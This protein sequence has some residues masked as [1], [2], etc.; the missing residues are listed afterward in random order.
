MSIKVGFLNTRYQ[1]DSLNK[2]D[3]IL[4]LNSFTNSNIILL[5]TEPTSTN[6]I[7]IK[8]KNNITT[9]V[10]GGTTYVIDDVVANSRLLSA[11]TNNIQFNRPIIANNTFSVSNMITAANNNISMNLG[12]PSSSRSFTVSSATSA[13]SSN[14]LKIDA[15][16]TT[17]LS[18]DNFRI[19]NSNQTKTLMQITSLQTNINQNL[20]INDGVLYVNTIAPIGNRKIDIQNAE[21]KQPIIESF[22]AT[23]KMSVIQP[24]T[25]GDFL[26]FEICKKYVAT[27]SANVFH[28]YSCNIVSGKSP[29]VFHNLVVNKDGLL[30]LGTNAPDATL[31]IRTLN[32]NIISYSGD[33]YGDIFK[34]TKEADLGIGT[35][36]PKAQVHIRRND[37][38]INDTIRRKPMVYLDMNYD[39]ANNYSNLYDPQN[40]TLTDDLIILSKPVANTYVL[41]NSFNIELT[42]NFYMINNTIFSA[43][44]NSV[45]NISNIQL[46]N[47]E[48]IEFSV[49]VSQPGMGSMY[50]LMNNKLIYP[51]SDNI[52]I[53]EDSTLRAQ[54]TFLEN[55][56]TIYQASYVF[57]MMSQTTKLTQGGYNNNPNAGYFNASN[58]TNYLTNAVMNK[59]NNIVYSINTYNI[60]VK[61]DFVFE[62]NLFNPF[63]QTAVVSYPIIYSVITRTLL[64][65]PQFMQFTYN[66]NFVS[67]ITT[68]GTLCI[69]SDLPATQKNKNYKIYAPDGGIRSQSINVSVIDTDQ[70][71]SNINISGKN[72]A[73]VNKLICKELDVASLAA[74]NIDFNT[75]SGTFI[76]MDVGHFDHIYT[77]NISFQTL[78]TG[79]LSMNSNSVIFQ[80]RVHCGSVSSGGTDAYI[81]IATDSNIVAVTTKGNIFNTN[82][83]LMVTN[84]DTVANIN[85]AITVQTVN[86]STT[87]YLCLNNS[88]TS[89]YFRV[90]TT[91]R[92]DNSTNTMFQIANDNID[93][94]RAAYFV[95]NKTS[96]HIMQHIKEYN[97]LSFGEQNTICIDTLRRESN[98]RNNIS[99]ISIGIPYGSIAQQYT[100]DDYP[101]YF[102]QTIN[103]DSN[104]YMLNIFGN[105]AVA[106]IAN[107]PVFTCITETDD[108][109][110]YVGINCHPNNVNTLRVQGDISASNIYLDDM[111]TIPTTNVT[112][113]LVSYL[114]E[115]EERIKILEESYRGVPLS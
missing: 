40:S 92:T 30:G 47:S 26:P 95:D 13:N 22:L 74:N 85:P 66:N 103:T 36:T 80:N 94:A 72:L 21:Y 111:L 3:D 23:R 38:E 75:V 105:V 45:D 83:G 101:K 63:N 96:P 102:A 17:E 6:D 14:I 81:K 114:R 44:G 59:F 51:G 46:Y 58:F 91:V 41:G 29:K 84:T 15:N 108:N 9:G 107:N 98:N 87:P 115:L 25:E 1:Y 61:I 55:D 24:P 113:D 43:M 106:N 57:F 93:D 62:K 42:N 60:R 78:N 69:G 86:T 99:K 8:F 4:T 82:T 28:A 7:F 110:V 35:A 89:Y 2:Q 79:Y 53:E 70:I 65:P 104:P 52:Y 112:K 73:N 77:S 49:P 34:L 48:V 54:S 18:S 16:K 10:T 11:N 76:D 32:N 19:L 88:E 12:Q 37:D 68:E 50:F 90:K 5:N 71:D 20:Y 67:S 27:G 39:A 64:S 109:K 97:V 56:Q 100:V 31:S 33:T